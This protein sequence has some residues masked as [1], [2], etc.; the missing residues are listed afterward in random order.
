ERIRIVGEIRSITAQQRISSYILTALPLI[1]GVIL[2][3]LNPGYMSKL[4]SDMCGWVL[5]GV[6]LVMIV[7]GFII[8]Q[9]IV[10]IEV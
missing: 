8:I 7:A 1:L 9:K 3:I 6:G 10:S 5:M 2:Y 4:W